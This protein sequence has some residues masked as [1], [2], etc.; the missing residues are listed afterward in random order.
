MVKGKRPK[1]ICEVCG[2]TDVKILERHHII[3]RT[4]INC[5]HDDFNIAV[6]CSNCHSKTHTGSLK[7]IGVYPGTRPPTGRILIYELNGVKNVDL[8]VPY[9][10]PQ[11]KEMKVYY[12][13]ESDST[14]G[15]EQEGDS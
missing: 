13:Q 15:G 6:L 14:D 5:T 12:G 8:D 2:E 1:I 4:D 3:P 11:P 10:S 7:I 9:C